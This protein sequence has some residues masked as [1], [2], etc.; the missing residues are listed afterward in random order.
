MSRAG[1]AR[2]SSVAGYDV[3]NEPNAFGPEQGLALSDLY[4][5]SLRAVRHAE[6]RAGGYRHL[7]LFEPSALWSET[8]SGAPPDF[9]HDRD[10]VYAPHIYT[11]GFTGGPITAAAFEVARTEARGFGGAPV[12]SGEWGADPGRAAPGGDSYFLDHQRLEDD[13]EFGATLWTWRE[14]CGDP[15]KVTDYREGRVPTVWGEFEVDCRTNAVVGVRH[16]LVGQLTRAYTRAAPGHL[17]RSVFDPAT[18]RFAAAG[19]AAHRGRRAGGVL[20]R[21]TVTAG[22][23][24]DRPAGPAPTACSGRSDAGHRARH[25]RARGR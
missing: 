18:R 1:S 21:D 6:R 22:R 10:V 9:P 23:Q 12:L 7:L 4:A 16:D 8:G 20:P 25:G 3:M 5:R 17:Q 2:T 14:S 19:T 15:H 13:F 11:G 24:V